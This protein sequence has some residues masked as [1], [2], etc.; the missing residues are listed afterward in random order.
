[1]Q[2]V[3]GM[4]AN[5]LI[6]RLSPKPKAWDAATGQVF[7]ETSSSIMHACSLLLLAA[8]NLQPLLGHIEARNKFLDD[9]QELR[10]FLLQRAREMEDEGSSSHFLLQQVHTNS[11]SQRDSRMHC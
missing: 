11:V 4:P 10:E 3:S 8:A 7:L 1:M 6:P 5:T 2:Y 9:V